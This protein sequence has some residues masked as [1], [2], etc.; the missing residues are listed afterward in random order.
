MLQKPISAG[1]TALMGLTA[2]PPTD[3]PSGAKQVARPQPKQGAVTGVV[4]RDF[5][6]GGG[7]VGKPEPGELGL[8]GVHVNLIDSSGKVVQNT[9]TA[10]D[11]SFTFDDVGNGSFKPRNRGV[12]VRRAV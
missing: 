9:T 12:D 10:E 6:P 2:I 4:W 5:K 11:G 7:V 3:V 8:P 1:G